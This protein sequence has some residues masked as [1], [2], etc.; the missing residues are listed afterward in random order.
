MQ[1]NMVVSS[2]SQGVAELGLNL[3]SDPLR[4]VSLG[5][6]FQLLELRFPLCKMR[7]L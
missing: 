7:S 4:H 2:T 5:M 1:S 3:A 6:L